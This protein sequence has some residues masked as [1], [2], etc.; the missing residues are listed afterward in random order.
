MN[1]G[2]TWTIYEPRLPNVVIGGIFTMVFGL[3]AIVFLRVG[4]FVWLA[5]LMGAIWAVSLALCGY[6]HSIVLGPSR[7]EI[8]VQYKVFSWQKEQSR[9]FQADVASFL[10]LPALSDLL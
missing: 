6:R 3:F 5:A 9:S 7:S 10:D 2:K 8:R 4:G 1:N